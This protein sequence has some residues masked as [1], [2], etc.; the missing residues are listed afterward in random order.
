MYGF[1]FDF[2][3]VCLCVFVDDMCVDLLVFVG[4]W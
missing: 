3:V 2:E 1:V 4:L